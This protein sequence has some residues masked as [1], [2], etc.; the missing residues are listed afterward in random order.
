MCEQL[1]FWES[2]RDLSVVSLTRNPLR[3]YT[4]HQQLNN[5][6]REN[7]AGNEY[8]LI[9]ELQTAAAAKALRQRTVELCPTPVYYQISLR[10]TQLGV[11]DGLTGLKGAPASNH[12]RLD[13]RPLLR[14]KQKRRL[15]YLSN[16]LILTAIL[17]L[18]PLHLSYLNEEFSCHDQLCSAFRAK[19]TD[20]ALTL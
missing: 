11:F 17:W 4:P 3:H 6:A 14:D 5:C 2:N 13:L 7:V 8:Q 16:S 10:T 12:Y 20:H 15:Q 18:E 9:D 19:L 1:A